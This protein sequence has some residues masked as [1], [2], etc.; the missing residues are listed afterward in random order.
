M[1]LPK[2]TANIFEYLQRGLFISSNSTDENIRRMFLTIE[3]H[4][5]PL[6]EYFSHINCFLEQGNEY[7]YFSRKEPKDTLQQKIERAFYWI[8]ILD[9]F[10]TFNETFGP[11]YRFS[12]SEILVE[13]SVN[14]ELQMKL[15]S[16]KKHSKGNEKRKE[17]LN[18]L[19]ERLVKES[20]IELESDISGIYKVMNAWNYLEQIIESINI[21]EDDEHEISE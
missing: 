1:E 9:F 6:Y 16:L 18:T 20:F 3:E 13:S 15:D 21:T 4:Y 14:P 11:G 2:N 7:Y 5:E 8:D 12:P 10:K 17:I 19:I